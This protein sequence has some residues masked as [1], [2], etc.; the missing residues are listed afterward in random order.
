MDNKLSNKLSNELTNKLSKKLSNEVSNKLKKRPV[1]AFILTILIIIFL[2]SIT[3]ILKINICNK[4]F[5]SN[6]YSNFI[7]VEILH[8]L[9]NIYGLYVL[10]RIEEK[11]GYKK[12]IFLI[13]ML[14]ILNTLFETLL[15][16]II[17]INC[18]VGFSAIL[19][20]MLSWEICSGCKNFNYEIIVAIVLNIISS[21]YINLNTSIISHLM[22]L[23]SGFIIGQ[24]YR[25]N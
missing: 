21:K 9:S 6:L 23:I 8:L 22:G 13:L 16:K 14:I 7:H 18:S 1:S 19:F 10:S 24:F 3:T 25:I 17:D 12:F 20:G 15:H 5:I 11:I 4:D 2:L